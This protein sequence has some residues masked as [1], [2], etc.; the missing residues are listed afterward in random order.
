MV[1]EICAEGRIMDHRSANEMVAKLGRVGNWA[2][3]DYICKCPKCASYFEGDK[4]STNCLSCA[5]DTLKND[6]FQQTQLREQFQEEVEC[7]HR[8]LDENQVA[9]EG[10]LGTLSLFG[11]VLEFAKRAVC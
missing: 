8:I 1:D 9:K 11:R 3:G 7:L 2:P 5:I 10:P 6:L 4:R